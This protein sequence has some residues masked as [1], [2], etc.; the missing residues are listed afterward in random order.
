VSLLF[1]A[2]CTSG[3]V[4]EVPTPECVAHYAVFGRPQEVSVVLDRSCAMQQRFDG[5]AASGATDPDGRWSAAVSAL[6]AAGADPSIDGWSLVLTPSDPAMCTLSSDLALYPEPGSGEMFADVLGATGA[7]P[8]EVCAAGTSEVPLE[9]ALGVV[10]GSF[11]IG[12]IGETLVVVI[13]AGAP[14][15]GSTALSLE[16]AAANTPYELAVIALS[17]DDAA[18]PLLQSLVL[19]DEE[20][21]RAR[22]YEATSAAEVTTLLADLIAERPSCTLDLVD[23]EGTLVTS[24]DELSVWIDGELAAQD[25]DEGWVLSEDGG[26]VLNGALCQRLR[27]GDIRHIDASLGCEEPVCVVIAPDDEGQGDEACDGLDNDCDEL[28]DEDCT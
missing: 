9:A 8:F 17:P 15:C 14:S 23:E 16:D 20:G 24:A 2:G 27:A 18:E 22:Y 11:D 21:M 28:I 10:N 1:A 26:I 13:A 6:V 7:S 4:M 19:P 25:P 12:Y 5:T 3:R